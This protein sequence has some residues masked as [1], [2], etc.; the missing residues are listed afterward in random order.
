MGTYWQTT[1][2]KA[3]HLCKCPHCGKWNLDPKGVGDGDVWPC[4]WE[5][6]GEGDT[7]DDPN[8][9]WLKYSVERSE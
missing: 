8:I 5:P 6:T 3:I 2:P 9:E 7:E 4:C 1:A